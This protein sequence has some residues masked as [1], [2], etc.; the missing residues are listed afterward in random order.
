MLTSPFTFVDATLAP[1][2]GVKAPAS[3][4]AKV[5]LDARQRAGF[6]TQ[7]A[8]L[9]RD[10]L[11]EPEPI[12]RGAFINHTF[13]CLELVPPPGA[14]E[15]APLPPASARTN[16]ERVNAITSAAECAVCHHSM[17]NPAGFAFENY[18]AIGRHRLTE[19]GVTIDAADTY[20]FPSSGPKSFKDGV[21]FSRILAESPEAHECYVKNWFTFLQGRAARPQDDPFVRWLGERSLRE[22]LPLRS[23]ALTVVTDDSFLSRLP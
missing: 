12:R 15:E 5:E 17:I 21:E 11:T 18:D 8:F 16:R 9:A 13:L 22:R 2:Y 3:G 23:L 10:G 1:L 6:L 14:T 7:T 19:N 4:F 20:R